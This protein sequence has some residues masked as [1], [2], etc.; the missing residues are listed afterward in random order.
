MVTAATAVLGGP[1]PFRRGAGAVGR[2]A[3]APMRTALRGLGWV[4]IGAGTLLAL[5]LVYSLYWTG[6]ETRGRQRDLLEAWDLEVGTVEGRLAAVVD[7]GDEPAADA[8]V[9]VGDAIAALQFR[10]PGSDAPIVLEEPVLVVEGVTPDALR[11]GP[12]HYPGT[13]LPGQPGNFAVAGHRTTYGAPFFNLDQAQP[14][15]EVHVTDRSGV[16]WVYEVVESKVVAPD[17]ISVLAPEPLGPG[18]PV[19]TLTTCNPR[20]SNRERLIVVAALQGPAD[21]APGQLPDQPTEGTA[22]RPAPDPTDAA[23]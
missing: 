9:A 4:L 15:D 18:T 19:L 8:P 2:A 21:A 1:A 20:F 16:R 23:A 10:R 17:D 3:W 22:R 5:Y 12:G 7:G 11:A 13:A 14:G 6:L